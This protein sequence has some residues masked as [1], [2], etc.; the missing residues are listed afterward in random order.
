MEVKGYLKMEKYHAIVSS[1][2]NECLA[3]CGPFDYI[4]FTYPKLKPHLDGIFKHYTGNRITLRDALQR[5][6]ALLPTQVSVE[7][8]D[9]YLDGAFKMYTGVADLMKWC[10][11]RQILFMINT[12]GAV[13]YF[14]RALFK[15]LLPP[16]SVISACPEPLYPDAASDPDKVYPLF[17]ISDKAKYTQ[18]VSRKLGVPLN[19]VIIIGDSGGD[20]PHFKWGAENGALLI[21]SMAKP[22][23]LQYCRQEG[24]QPDYTFGHTYG[25]GETVEHESEM[26]F[27][28]K[29]LCAVIDTAAAFRQ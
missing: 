27:N 3:P 5:V 28:F 22:S 9:A 17:K 21:A 25:E 20:G 23:L 2:W 26:A 13:G 15:K 7:Q 29:E 16:L 10:R 14:Q 6:R 12:T 4:A 24:I 8:M 1:D 18:K 19:R 11:S